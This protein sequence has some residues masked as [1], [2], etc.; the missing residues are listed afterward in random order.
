VCGCVSM[1]RCVVEGRSEVRSESPLFCLE[2]VSFF[3]VE[4]GVV[5]PF[6]FPFPSLS[7]SRLF[8][9]LP[10]CSLSLLSLFSSLSLSPTHKNTNITGTIRRS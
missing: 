7:P 5:S 1:R 2:G 3:F 4:K 10:F 9:P 8:P 6:L